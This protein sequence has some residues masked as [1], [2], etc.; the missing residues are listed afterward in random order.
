MVNVL[1]INPADNV[2]VALKELPAGTIVEASDTLPPIKT[3]EPIPFGHK[4]AISIITVGSSVVKYGASIG[5][6]V[7][8]INPGQHVHI[9]NLHSVRGAAIHG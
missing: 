8:D 7:S 9:H 2:V 1:L 3:C 6:A 5:L 4:I